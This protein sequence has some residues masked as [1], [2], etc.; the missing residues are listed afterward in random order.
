M[1]LEANRKETIAF[2]YGSR[3]RSPGKL[4]MRGKLKEQR[5]QK[6]TLTEE[7]NVR[8]PVSEESRRSALQR[9]ACSLTLYVVAGHLFLAWT[10]R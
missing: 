1:E 6:T 3:T 2:S 5:L 4:Q 8:L 10:E 9:S 7:Q